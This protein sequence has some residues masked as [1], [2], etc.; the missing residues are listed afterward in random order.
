MTERS[1][2]AATWSSR[3]WE[4]DL[5]HA[6]SGGRD[7][8]LRHLGSLDEYV[9]VQVANSSNATTARISFKDGL[10][11]II[12]W[13]QPDPLG[14]PVQTFRMIELIFAYAPQGGFEKA[15]SI[16]NRWPERQLRTRIPFT[17]ERDA[18][19]YLES[20]RALEK[21]FPA[22]PHKETTAYRLY[23]ATLKEQ[24]IRPLY[25]AYS[26]ARLMALGELRLKDDLFAEWIIGH[27]QTIAVLVQTFVSDQRDTIVTEDLTELYH[28][29]HAAAK[30]IEFRAAVRD[31]G[32]SITSTSAGGTRGVE[33]WFGE[34]RIA[35]TQSASQMRDM[36]KTMVD[37]NVF[38]KQ[39]ERVT[40]LS[41]GSADD[42]LLFQTYREH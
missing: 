21:Y 8:D 37:N 11:R 1:T 27:P 4:V 9:E 31:C 42:G 17:A 18:D 40:P 2:D 39:M 25:A 24:I 5:L 7:S 33:I 22:T 29:C 19:L 14:K 15:L 26:A 3:E 13:W 12:D 34:R 32:G 36:L 23:V 38:Q 28:R 20:L 16:L 41:L 10:E 35:L 30:L 6:T